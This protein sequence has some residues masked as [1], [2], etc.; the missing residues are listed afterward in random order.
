MVALNFYGSL[1]ERRRKNGI[2]EFYR[3]QRNLQELL[4]EDEELLSKGQNDQLKENAHE[5]QRKL[6]WDT[7]LARIT[8]LLNIGMIIA[9]TI[10]AYLSNSISIISSVVD[11]VMDITSGTVIWICIRLIRKTNRYEYPIHPIVDLPTIIIMVT[12]TVLKAILFLVCRRQ[13]TPGSMVLAMD[14]RNDVLT[15]IVALAGA[16]IGNHFWLYADPL[17]A[18][19]VWCVH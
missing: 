13:K 8:L 10:A 16:Y 14:Q 7:W 9:K 15:N 5:D 6:K 19:F 2:K 18:F 1:R 4:K 11:S 17:G 3:Y 12:G